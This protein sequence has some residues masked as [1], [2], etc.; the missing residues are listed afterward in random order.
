MGQA[1]PGGRVVGVDCQD[2]F[3]TN[4]TVFVAVHGTTQ[5][6]PCLF[7]ALVK[8]DGL[9]QQ[10]LGL[11]RLALFVR[12]NPLIHQLIDTVHDSLHEQIQSA[13]L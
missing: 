5:P 12:R 9:H 11:D 1:F 4:E 6:Q 2:I 8:L 10:L 7:I 3:Q 13:T